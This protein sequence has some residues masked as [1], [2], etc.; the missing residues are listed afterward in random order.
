MYVLPEANS[1]ARKTRDRVIAAAS[2][3]CIISMLSLA[4]VLATGEDL[5][6]MA[7]HAQTSEPST[8]DFVTTWRTT[9]ANESIT[10]PVGGAAGTY[11]VD[12]GD[13]TSSTDVTGDQTHQYAEAGEYAVRISGDFTRIYLNGDRGAQKLVS[14]DQWGDAEWSSMEG[15]FHGA[16]KMTYKA[17]DVP[18]LSGVTSMKSM[19]RNASSFNGDVSGWD[20]SSVTDMSG[21]FWNASSFNGDV[22]G[23]VTSSVTDMSGMFRNTADFNGDVSGWDVSSVTDMS[24][25]FWNASSFNGDVSGWVTSSVTD[26]SGMFRNTA[27]FNGDL[28]GWDVSSVTDMSFMFNGARSFNGDL[29][30]WDVSSVIDM[31]NMF[32]WAIA[33]NY[34]ISDWDVSNVAYMSGMFYGSAFDQNLGKWYVVL[35]DTSA[36]A[37]TAGTTVGNISAQNAL[38]DFQNPAYSLGTGGDSGSFALDG[39]TLKL[40]EDLSGGAYTVTIQSTGSFGTNNSRTYEVTVPNKQPV[41]DA[42]SDQT[43]REGDTVTLGGTASDPDGD[44]MTY[45]WTHDSSLGITLSS[46]TSLSATFTAPEVDSDATV[47]FTLTADD[48]TDSVSDTVTVTIN[49]FVM[50]MHAGS[51]PTASATAIPDRPQNLQ[52]TSAGTTVT[53]TWDDPDD[54]TITGYKILSR[55]HTPGTSL[56]VLVEDTGSAGTSYTATGLESDTDYIFRIIAINE[57]G[58]SVSSGPV[59][60][61]TGSADQMPLRPQNL[62]ATSTVTAVTLTWDDPD[63]STITGYKILSRVHTPGTSLSV[64]VEDTGSAGTSYTATDLK[65]ETAYIFRVV[66]VNENGKSPPSNYVGI[67]TMP[68]PPPPRPQNL[69]ATS[70]DTT[71][72]L[73]WDDGDDT[74]I[75]GYQILSR[76]ATPGTTLSIMASY[77]GNVDS[78]HTATG[79]EPDTTYVF[80]VITTNKYGESDASLPIRVSTSP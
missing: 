71:V 76:V 41:V 27:D 8:T 40:K 30:G 25:M 20:V 54:S 39:S 72:T 11:S 34:D 80:R 1:H 79:L 13:G 14:I 61:T 55:V 67:S 49:K 52:A 23:W 26:M 68:H 63:D 47:T 69:Q 57:K 48:G 22:S 18:D 78:S 64:L 45:T 50:S 31:Y 65:P 62:Q 24:G 56:S 5:R 42:G 7:A 21:M 12:W 15:A 37:G 4:A 3:L 35:D 66:A 60:I 53:L 46:T 43:V 16:S 29:S 36:D 59:R 2:L 32:L 74:S 10:I 19:F 28:S 70:T 33:F 44:S 17:T 75:N 38:L 58:Q 77:I 73:T 51:P 6:G 9:S